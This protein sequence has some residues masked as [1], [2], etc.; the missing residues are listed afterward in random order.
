MP[1]HDIHF[2]KTAERLGKPYKEI[3]RL[4]DLPYHNPALRARHRMIFHDM[5]TPFLIANLY[6]TSSSSNISNRGGRRGIGGGEGGG[7]RRRG[8][9]DDPV[10]IL[11]AVISHYIDDYRLY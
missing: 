8:I 1:G 3:H 6:A 11:L 4:L 10:M 7:R 5:V 9:E 2:R